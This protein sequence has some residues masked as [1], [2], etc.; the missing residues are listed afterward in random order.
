M[1]EPQVESDQSIKE[2]SSPVIQEAKEHSSATSHELETNSPVHAKT[3]LAILAVCLIY[4]AQLT[5]VVGAGA[6]GQTIIAH[7]N[8][9]AI[10]W[11]T[12]PIAIVTVVL[13]PI[14]AQAADYWGRKWFLIVCAMFGAIGSVVIARATSMNMVIAGFTLTGVAFGAQPLL[15]TVSLL[16]FEKILTSEVLPR[17]W[18]S[19]GQAIDMV[20]TCLGTIFG[21]LVG[22][23]LNRNND[24]TSDGF[25][26]YFLICMAWYLIAAILCFVVYNPPPFENQQFTT[27]EKL[28]K[29]DWIGYLLLAA[30]LVLFSVGL[31]YSQ[32]PY[33]WNDPH[34]SA[35]FAV[36]LVLFLCLIG[37]ETYIKKDGMFHHGLFT[38]NRNFAISVLTVSCEGIA[39]FAANNYLIFQI[40]TLYESDALIVATRYCIM[41][42]SAS[43]GALAAGWYCAAYK[44]V[45]WIAV[46]AFVIFLIFFICMATSNTGS[47]NAVWFYPVLLGVGLGMTLTTLVTAAQLSTPPELIAEASGL[48]L[49]ARSLGGTIAIAIYNALFNNEI[50]HMGEN[51]ASAAISDG[52]SSEYVE[53]FVTVLSAQSKNQTALLAIPGVTPQI[54][55]AGTQALLDTY[56]QAFRH[57]YIAA[58]CFVAVAAILAS[59]LFDPQQEFNMHIDAPIEKVAEPSPDHE[60]A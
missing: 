2:P 60:V 3:F 50:A 47:S 33:Q 34:V 29:L 57:V 1:A 27:T 58:A 7:F 12:A 51:I 28:A 39:Y 21:L 9:T 46:A 32:N 10:V 5:S 49:S 48:M 35:T 14:V 30:G 56:V 54:V 36:G 20:A 15:H 26:T 16:P 40:G 18:R 43:L 53:D 24:P 59:F 8:S 55:E 11:L 22:G 45:R 13:G 44:R 23:A 38:G 37:Y 31:S 42:I 25:R 6:Q 19:W 17:R 52:L 4:F 41:L